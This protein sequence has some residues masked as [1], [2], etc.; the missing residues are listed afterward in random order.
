MAKVAINGLGRIGRAALKI[1]LDTPGLELTAVNDLATA[2]QL[3][4]LLRYDTVYGRYKRSVTGEGD[5]LVIDGQRYR[6]YSEKDPSQ[7][8]WH[9]LGVD[10]VFE[11]TG[12]FTTR[13]GCQKHLQA[14]ACLVILSAPSKAEDMPTFIYGVNNIADVR[15]NILSTAS[16]TTNS[17]A[18]VVEIIGRRIGM[19]KAIMTTLHAY[20]SSQSL[21][22]A[23]NKKL[24][25]GRAAA[26]NFVPATTGAAKATTRA[27]PQYKGMFEATAVRAPVPIGS[28]SDIVF[29]TDRQTSIDEVNG[30]LK[31]EAASSRYNGIVA[32]SGDEIV[33]SDIIMDD[34]AAILDL[35]MT[36]VCG[37]DLV[38]VMSWYDNEWGYTSQMVRT[39][40]ALVKQMAGAAV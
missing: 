18:P 14:G 12:H 30:I 33:S 36:Q 39:A 3:A 31:E 28:V 5:H 26:Q 6:V 22:D 15:D 1:I 2:E 9:D 37:G 35:T 19:K 25:R 10:V 21:V 29:M 40:A 17:V 11:C 32:V 34:H 16:C 24:R 38:K 20:T 7:L 4:Y 8:P 27:L 13:E 23:P